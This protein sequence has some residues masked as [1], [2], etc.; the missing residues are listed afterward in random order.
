[1]NTDEVRIAVRNA[2]IGLLLPIPLIAV[3]TVWGPVQWGLLTFGLGLVGFSW[4]LGRP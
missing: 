3:A 2:G 4:W 1:M